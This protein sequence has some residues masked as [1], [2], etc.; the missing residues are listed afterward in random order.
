MFILPGVG[1]GILCGLNTIQ[2]VCMC[3]GCFSPEREIGGGG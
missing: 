3:T 1:A 2:E